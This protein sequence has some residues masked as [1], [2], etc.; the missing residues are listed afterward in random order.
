MGKGASS[1]KEHGGRVPTIRECE[2]FNRAF[3]KWHERRFGKKS[4]GYNKYKDTGS[5]K[6]G[7]SNRS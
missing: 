4:H 5:G 1:K 7:K 6:F 3:N 2:E